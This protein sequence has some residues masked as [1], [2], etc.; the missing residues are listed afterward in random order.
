MC[1]SIGG[2][3]FLASESLIIGAIL[4]VVGLFT[5]V[6]FGFNLFTGKA[7]YLLDN[8]GKYAVNTAIIWVGNF[9][10]AFLTAQLISLTRLVSISARAK[11]LVGFKLGDDLISI[12]ILAIF[13]NIL[14]F[15]A[16]D[17]FKNNPHEIGK[18][19]S[20]FF[21]VVVFIVCGFEHCIANMFY[22]SMAGMW[23]TEAFIFILVNSIGNLIGG[24]FI[25]VMKKVVISSE[26]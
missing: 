21:G 5:I 24:L 15:I 25:P 26:A 11:E 9:I 13:C 18:Y 8:D 12:F 22:I 4:F 1:I 6:T 3:T 23:N 7:C 2:A 10:G 14:I 20:L 17:G 16:V 19:F